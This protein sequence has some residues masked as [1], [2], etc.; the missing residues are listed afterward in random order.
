M[1]KT[2]PGGGERRAEV[3]LHAKALPS[4]ISLPRDVLSDEASGAV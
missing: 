2:P 1:A 4:G 3:F